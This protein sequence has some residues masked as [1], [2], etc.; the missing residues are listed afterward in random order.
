[1]KN[2]IKLGWIG[3]GFVSQVAHLNSFSSIPN[4]EIVTLSEIRETLGKKNCQK[5]GIRKFYNNYKEMIKNEKLD[6]VVC[7]VRRYQTYMI[8]KEILKNKINLFTEK[9]MAPT[10]NKLHI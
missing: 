8:A 7:I 3:S 1:M 10:L 9:P 5:F 4:V 2:N 6:A